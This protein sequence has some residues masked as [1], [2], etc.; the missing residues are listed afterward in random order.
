[1]PFSIAAVELAEEKMIILG[2]LAQGYATTDVSV[3]SPVE[4]VVEP[5]YRLDGVDRLVWR[6]KPITEGAR[7]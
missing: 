1:V 7:S 3:G 4:L 5:L 2:Q 6:W